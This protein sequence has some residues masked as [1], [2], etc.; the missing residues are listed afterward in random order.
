MFQLG[1]EYIQICAA[2][3]LIK[4]QA[5]LTLTSANTV[6]R[7]V[8]AKRPILNFTKCP[9]E[10]YA[11]EIELRMLWN[12]RK[13]LRHSIFSYCI[14]LKIGKMCREGIPTETLCTHPVSVNNQV[15][16]T[17]SKEKKW[18]GNN[19]WWPA[20]LYIAYC[21]HRPHSYVSLYRIC[22]QWSRL[23]VSAGPIAPNLISRRLPLHRYTE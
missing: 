8:D 19:R 7:L 14:D 18:S 2:Q 3:Y 16:A 13:S 21:S 6:T 5:S 17:T 9:W 22:R 23:L 10:E 11:R 4:N 20:Y 12:E 1:L 15:L